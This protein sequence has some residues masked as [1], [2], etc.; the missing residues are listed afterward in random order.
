MNEELLP[1]IT[2]ISTNKRRNGTL[3]ITEKTDKS[4]F[5]AREFLGLEI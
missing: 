5:R 1:Q 2:Q 3:M 4:G